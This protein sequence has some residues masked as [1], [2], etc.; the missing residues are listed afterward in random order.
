[1][2]SV[3]FFFALSSYF[4]P[5]NFTLYTDKANNRINLI[6]LKLYQT[7]NTRAKSTPSCSEQKKKLTYLL[8]R[9]SVQKS[10]EV[11]GNEERSQKIN[12]YKTR[13]MS[14][15]KKGSAKKASLI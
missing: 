15:E 4:Y 10:P 12:L 8:F 14:S 1:L 13:N 9:Q 5:I 7:A 6:S 2:Q 3:N 11:A